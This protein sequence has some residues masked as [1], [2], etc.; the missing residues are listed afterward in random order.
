MDMDGTLT[1]FNLDYTSARQR[2]L[3]EFDRL[4][5]RTENMNEQTSIFLILKEL[6]ATID[7]HTFE[8]LRANVNR[9]LEKT[10]VK[11]A[12]EVTLHPGVLETLQEL[13]N[14]G[15]RIGIV[16]NNGQAGT[17]LTLKRY[18]MQ[19]YFDTVVTRDNYKEVK[20]DAAPIHRAL[21]ELQV[22]RQEA[23]FVG[24]GTW[25][26]VAAKAAGLQSVAVLTEPYGR[27]LVLKTEPEYLLGSIHDLTILIDFLEQNARAAQG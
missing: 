27:Q 26:I 11:A 6:K 23:I 16:T 17:A 8:V 24:D 9:I 13:R 21:M 3:R 19:S 12:K 5:V 15:I 2:I 18:Q 1:K 14:R 20:P 4:N 7:A 10:E 25:D 22:H